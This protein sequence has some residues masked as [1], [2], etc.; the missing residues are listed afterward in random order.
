MLK[1]T[2]HHFHLDNRILI[3]NVCSS[4][5]TKQSIGEPP[6]LGAVS[7]F[8]AIKDAIKSARSDAGLSGNFRLDSP[9]TPE[10]I[11]MAC[12]DML[13]KMV[14]TFSSHHVLTLNN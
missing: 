13:S 5:I 1:F 8:F 9:A 7:V 12:P 3:Y 4:I 11:R 10:R 2:K 6:V 14:R